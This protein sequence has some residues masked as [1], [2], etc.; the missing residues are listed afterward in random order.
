MGLRDNALLLETVDLVEETSL[1]VVVLALQLHQEG[2]SPFLVAS[3]HSQHV[4]DSSYLSL[5]L[6]HR[7]Q[8]LQVIL[9]GFILGTFLFT[10]LHSLLVELQLLDDLTLSISDFD[11]LQVLLSPGMQH[12]VF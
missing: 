11:H 1:V 7:K 12:E 9:N 5:P 10:R 6:L 2:A 3:Q 4:F 8:A